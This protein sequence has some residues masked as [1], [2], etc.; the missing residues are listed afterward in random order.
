MIGALEYQRPARGEERV[1]ANP[2]VEGV[3][4]KVRNYQ[5]KYNTW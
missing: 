2:D 3:F 1:S 4:S 5:T